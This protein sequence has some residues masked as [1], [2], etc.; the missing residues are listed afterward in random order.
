MDS[1]IFR[2]SGIGSD[3]SRRGRIMM[4]NTRY[5][6]FLAFLLVFLSGTAVVQAGPIANFTFIET[7]LGGGIWQYDYM[8][9][10]LS[11]PIA[12]AGFDLYSLSLYFDPA[13]TFSVASLPYGWEEID[14]TGFADTFSIIPGA[15][16]DG[17]DIAAGTSLSG[18]RFLFNYRAGA[19]PFQVL[20]VNPA[21]FA[22]PAFYQGNTSSVPE[23]TSTFVLAI[24]GIT[25]VACVKRFS[26]KSGC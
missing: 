3:H 1:L 10:N 14:G 23:P 11:D 24:I 5:L 18:F 8:L 9:T 19:L 20:F 7:D 26:I 16:P 21:D 12:D 6:A 22:N 4:L 17:A 13:A 25:A 2:K 15:F